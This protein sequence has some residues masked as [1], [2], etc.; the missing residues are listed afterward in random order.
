MAGYNSGLLCICAKRHGIGSQ[1]ISLQS[2]C[3]AD[4]EELLSILPRELADSIR[5]AHGHGLPHIDDIRD[6]T[7]TTPSS[8]NTGVAEDVTMDEAE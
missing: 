8:S 1:I 2:E 5:L 6:L 3:Q 7:E 4:N